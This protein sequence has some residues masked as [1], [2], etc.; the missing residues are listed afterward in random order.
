LSAFLDDKGKKLYIRQAGKTLT[1]W[2]RSW[3]ISMC[4]ITPASSTG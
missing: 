2:G 3:T 1:I 4:S